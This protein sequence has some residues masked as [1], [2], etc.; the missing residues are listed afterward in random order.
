M[1][2]EQI[3]IT[4]LTEMFL[5]LGQEP[6][7]ERIAYYVR[8]LKNVPTPYLRVACDSAVCASKS[9]FVPG[10]GEIIEHAERIHRDKIRSEREARD[11][12]IQA[13]LDSKRIA[14][15]A[16]HGRAKPQEGDDGVAALIDMS[17]RRVGA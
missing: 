14:W 7:P 17:L 11:A 2:D 3:R 10:P 13:E 9:G 16:E 12:E 1:S 6:T 15:D 4:V 8:L 5:G